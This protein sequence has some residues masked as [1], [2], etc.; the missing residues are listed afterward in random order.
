MLKDYREFY[1]KSPQYRGPRSGKKDPTV[2]Q[3]ISEKG[4]IKS[5]LDNKV[6]TTKASYMES[7]KR[8]GHHI[9]E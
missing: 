1:E 4:G 3:Y 8:Q 9:H 6:Y 5:H 2:D 7:L